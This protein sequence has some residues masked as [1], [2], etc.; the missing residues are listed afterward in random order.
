MIAYLTGAEAHIL[1]LG[2]YCFLVAT[3]VYIAEFGKPPEEN[4]AD[5]R[6]FSGYEFLATNHATDSELE[7]H[8]RPRAC[9]QENKKPIFVSEPSTD[10]MP[11]ETAGASMLELR[12]RLE[13]LFEK[14]EVS[15][16]LYITVGIPRYPSESLNATC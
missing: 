8:P 9:K 1:G 16:K 10:R 14:L 3:A 2:F 6:N 11:K 4:A 12:M 7:T 5:Y 13:E 15:T